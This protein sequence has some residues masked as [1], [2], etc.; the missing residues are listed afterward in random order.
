MLQASSFSRLNKVK[1]GVWDAL[2][3]LKCLGEHRVHTCRAADQPLMPPFDHAVQTAELCRL[4]HPQH[5]WLHLVG[6][7]HSLG[8]LMALPR[9]AYSLL[10]QQ[11]IGAHFQHLFYYRLLCDMPLHHLAPEVYACC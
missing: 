9:F 3:Q 10:L 1:L 5:D 6:L 8:K 7:I 4:A 2:Q 11:R